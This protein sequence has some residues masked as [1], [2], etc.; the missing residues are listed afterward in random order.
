MTL[1]NYIFYFGLILALNSGCGLYSFSGSSIP[2]NA[3][4]VHIKETQNN[5]LLS[6][7][8]LAQLITEGLNNY[9]LTETNL[10]TSTKNPDLLFAGK[11]TK[12][13]V[14]PISINSQ[15]NASQNRLMIEVEMS[16]ENTTDT[17]NNFTRKFSNYM[18]FDSSE[19]FLD[20]ENELNELIVDKLVEDIF[21]AS[22]SNW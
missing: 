6:N 9:I 2:K 12:Y 3:Q 10:K 15:N 8:E 4:T 5:T 7:P 11:V 1:N 20:V 21:Y 16:Y 13:T 22:F 17:L 19:N 14:S 18:D